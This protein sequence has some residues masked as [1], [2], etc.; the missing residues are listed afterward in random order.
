MK[1]VLACILLLVCLGPAWTAAPLPTLAVLPLKEEGVRGLGDVSDTMNTLV[2]SAFAESGGF[3]L[4]ER[5]QLRSVLAESRYQHS[6]LV[7]DATIVDLGKQL[8]VRFVLVGSYLPE[9]SGTSLSLTL[10]LRLVDVE[11][12]S[13]SR[14]FLES[15]EAPTLGRVVLQLSHTLA[16]HVS[17]LKLTESSPAGP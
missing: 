1:K 10:S 4:V 14:S 16:D 15:A 12:A 9:R 17:R 7:D 11:R 3:Q 13:I 2:T 5:H 8:G 6:G